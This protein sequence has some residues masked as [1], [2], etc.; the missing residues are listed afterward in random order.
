M[1]KKCIYNGCIYLNGRYSP[2]SWCGKTHNPISSEYIRDLH[3]HA[4][5]TNINNL[6]LA[7]EPNNKFELCRCCLN[8]INK[9]IKFYMIDN[10]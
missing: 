10:K 5:V 9:Q 3:S 1:I 4:P 8:S 2:T 6:E 7:I